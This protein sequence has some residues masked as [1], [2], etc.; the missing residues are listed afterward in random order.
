MHEISCVLKRDVESLSVI[1]FPECKSWWKGRSRPWPWCSRLLNV[2]IVILTHPAAEESV[3]LSV[4][5][6]EPENLQATPYNSSSVLV[7]WERPR[8]V[9]DSSINTYSVTYRLAD[10]E[11]A[12]MFR[13][14][15]DGDQD[16][17]RCPQ[18]NYK[19]NTRSTETCRLAADWTSSLLPPGGDSGWSGSQQKLQCSGDGHLLQRPEGASERPTEGRGAPGC[20]G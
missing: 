12:E 8:A 7:T 19:K 17:V 5:S 11:D 6:S 15:T 2:L 3:C 18:L 10:E 9:Y 4:C 1:S 14:M 20:S 13:Y 16:V